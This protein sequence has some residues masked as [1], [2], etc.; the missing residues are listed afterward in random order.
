MENN[1]NENVKVLRN[2]KYWLTG[3]KIN[4]KIEDDLKKWPEYYR[5]KEL[6]GLI[7]ET[8]KKDPGNFQFEIKLSI[9]NIIG[10]NKNYLSMEEKIEEK[11]YEYLDSDIKKTAKVLFQSIRILFNEN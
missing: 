2:N 9:N 10:W 3:L 11:N 8:K 5:I 4:Q 7:T 6:S 1:S